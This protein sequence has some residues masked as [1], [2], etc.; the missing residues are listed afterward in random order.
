MYYFRISLDGEG[1]WAAF[2]APTGDLM[3]R[4][5]VYPDRQDAEN[6]VAVMQSYA[7]MAPVRY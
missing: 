1:Y 3:W 6:A 5:E 4:S 2:Y 7:A